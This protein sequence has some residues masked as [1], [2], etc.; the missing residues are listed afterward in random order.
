VP[1]AAGSQEVTAG[2]DKPESALVTDFVMD[3][4][5]EGS[6]KLPEGLVAGPSTAFMDPKDWAKLDKATQQEF[7]AIFNP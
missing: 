6:S 2:T 1:A 4:D 7:L 5:G 3:A